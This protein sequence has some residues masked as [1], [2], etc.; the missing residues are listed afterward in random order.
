MGQPIDL[1]EERRIEVRQIGPEDREALARGGVARFIRI[2]ND[3]AEPAV[4]VADDWQRHGVGAILLERLAQ[5]AWDEGIRTFAASALADDTAA[6]ALL[7]NLGPTRTV[8]HGREVELLISLK[9][10]RGALGTL[11]SLLRHAAEQTVHPSASVWRRWSEG[12]GA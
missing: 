12:D 7:S 1:G 5:R 3:V 6:I 8:N 4:A 2:E 10:R 9:D 11:H